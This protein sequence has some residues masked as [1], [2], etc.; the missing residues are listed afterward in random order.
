MNYTLDIPLNINKQCLWIQISHF[1]SW[2]KMAA[3]NLLHSFTVM[4]AVLDRPPATKWW[5]S[6]L[7][8]ADNLPN[9]PQLI[10][11][12]AYRQTKPLYRSLRTHSTPFSPPHSPIYWAIN[13]FYLRRRRWTLTF[14]SRDNMAPRA[15]VVPRRR[16]DPLYECHGSSRGAHWQSLA[17]I[18]LADGYARLGTVS[19][20]CG[21][22]AGSSNSPRWTSRWLSGR[23]RR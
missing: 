21:C 19:N 18:V 4:N 3:K 15:S 8:S 16:E 12:L 5:T 9:G 14:Q 2:I 13:I 17:F 10:G 11:Q 20:A 6:Y 7:A 1:S 22:P 23:W